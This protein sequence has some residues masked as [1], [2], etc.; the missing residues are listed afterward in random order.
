MWCLM[1]GHI[2]NIQRKGLLGIAHGVK[3]VS[4]L[5]YEFKILEGY[6][7]IRGDGNETAAPGA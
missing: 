2:P 5:V 4:S 7:S 6:L 1:M 3:K